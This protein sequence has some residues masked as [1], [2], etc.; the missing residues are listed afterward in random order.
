MSGISY[1]EIGGQLIETHVDSPTARPQAI[2][3][4]SV[5]KHLDVPTPVVRAVSR[6]V[7]KKT[8]IDPMVVAEK[9]GRV[10]RAKWAFTTAAAIA[11]A[12]GPLPFGDIAAIGF[13]G[14]YGLYEMHQVVTDWD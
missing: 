10:R 6:D 4:K 8:G 14:A 9:Y 1:F 11:A 5:A 3:A 13:L 12:D 2:T 7:K